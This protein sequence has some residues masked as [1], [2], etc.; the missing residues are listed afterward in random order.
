M[1][2]QVIRLTKIEAAEKQLREA[3]RLFAEGRDPVTVQT[4]VGAAHQVLTI[5]KKAL[6]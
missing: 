4:V 6:P 5:F 3:I 1:S 2:L